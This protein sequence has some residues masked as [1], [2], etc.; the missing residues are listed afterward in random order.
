VSLVDPQAERDHV[1]VEDEH[2]AREVTSLN[3][4]SQGSSRWGVEAAAAAVWCGAFACLHL[5]WALGGSIGLASSAG[6]DLAE[7][8]PTSFVIFGLFGVAMFLVVGIGVI[9]ATQSSRIAERWRHAATVL[10]AVVGVGLA[11]RGV[12][13][14]VLLAMNVGGLQ[15]SVG[16]LETYWGLVLWNPWFAL[17]GALFIV[18]A[19]RGSSS[20]FHRGQSQ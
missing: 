3:V 18:T 6:Y 2:A 16:P 17:G 12:A 13:L 11:I 10:V 14:E 1:P 20:R 5:F 15:A 9:A 19:I 8:R 4:D 7:R